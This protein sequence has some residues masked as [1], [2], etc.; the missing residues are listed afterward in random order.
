MAAI[1][2]IE[3]IGKVYAA[4]LN[5][6]AVTTVEG[7]LKKG[8]TPKGRKQLAESTGI[9]EKLVLKWVNR[10]DLYRVKGVAEEYS[11]LL[12][13]AGVDTVVELAQRNPAH[14]HA[15]L[16]ETNAAKKAVRH[17]PTAEKV[18]EWVAEAKGL[19][20]VVTY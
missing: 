9:S 15:K 16:V 10:A 6:A 1:I 17:L 5:A 14:L 11:D 3:G 12:E 13:L 4:K 20:R 2:D 18:G 19:P 8:A 7:L